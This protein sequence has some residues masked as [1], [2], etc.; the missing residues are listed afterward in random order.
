MAKGSSVGFMG[1]TIMKEL[2]SSE[3]L[4]KVSIILRV[5][6]QRHAR[7]HCARSLHRVIAQSQS[8]RVEAC[9]REGGPFR[10]QARREKCYS[11]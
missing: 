1:L 9:K 4:H 11:V 3:S 2:S 8:S 7:S 10:A 5:I 6:A